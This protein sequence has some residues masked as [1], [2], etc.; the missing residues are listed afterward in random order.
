MTVEIRMTG[1]VHDQIHRDLARPHPFA[2]ERIGFVFG[3]TGSLANAAK[4]VLLTR[5]HSIPD[6]QYME[7]ETVGARIGS[8]A[9]TWAMQAVYHGRPT[10]EGIL[11]VHVHPHNGKTGMSRIDRREIPKLMPGFQSVG[12]EA[13]HGIMILSND[14]GAGWVWLPGRKEP[15]TVHAISVIGKPLGIFE[16][17][18]SG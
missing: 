9:L 18:V 7:D 15:V 3:R 1:S 11:H 12:R 4:L 14:H 6:E 2:T 8:D 13:T 17:G 10:R 16:M 5:Y